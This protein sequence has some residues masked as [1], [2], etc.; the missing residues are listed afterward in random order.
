MWNKSSEI[1]TMWL[2]DSY[3]GSYFIPTIFLTYLSNIHMLLPVAS[4][5]IIIATN[6][7]GTEKQDI[8]WLNTVFISIETKW[9]RVWTTI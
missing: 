7:F 4:K 3:I 8:Y 6:Q 9:C 1:A 2:I 5:K